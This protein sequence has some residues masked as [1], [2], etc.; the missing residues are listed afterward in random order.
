VYSGNR[1]F[2]NGSLGEN[3]K[4]DNPI[5]NNIN[6]ENYNFNQGNLTRVV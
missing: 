4:A 5:P 1:F 3:S 6:G 2:E